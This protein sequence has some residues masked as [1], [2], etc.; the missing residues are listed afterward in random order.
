MGHLRVYT[1]LEFVACPVLY[2][3]FSSILSYSYIAWAHKLS[4]SHD[5]TIHTPTMPYYDIL[6]SI[7]I[8]EQAVL[9]WSTNV[10]TPYQRLLPSNRL[11]RPRLLRGAIGEPTIRPSP[12]VG[13]VPSASPEDGGRG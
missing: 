8:P 7:Q 4:S 12:S 13:G 11:P 6:F 5:V 3:Q 9:Q 10:S 1:L 2:E